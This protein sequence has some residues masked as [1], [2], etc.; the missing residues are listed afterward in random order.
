MR[1]PGILGVE[2]DEEQADVFAEWL[3]SR[4]TVRTAYTAGEAA[5]DGQVAMVTAVEPDFDIIEMG[6]DDYLQKPVS[7]D[8]LVPIRDDDGGRKM[9]ERPCS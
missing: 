4:Y 5:D 2:D 9:Y 7:A 3:R 1:K 8:D 6:F